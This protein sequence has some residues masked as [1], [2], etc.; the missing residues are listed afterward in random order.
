LN[1]L[2]IASLFTVALAEAL[3]HVASLEA[4]LKI[5]SKALKDAN[6]AKTSAKK[7]AKAAEARASKAEKA[8]AKVAKKQATREGAIVE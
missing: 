6:T 5:T 3:A 1:L 8:L 4:E 7:S 2:Y